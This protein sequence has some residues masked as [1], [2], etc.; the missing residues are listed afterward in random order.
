MK[1]F[2]NVFVRVWNLLSVC[3]QQIKLCRRCWHTA[4]LSRHSTDSDCWRHQ[5]KLMSRTSS[6][7][8][9]T[10]CW[11]AQTPGLTM[12]LWEVTS[13]RQN[14]DV[15]YRNLAWQSVYKK[16]RQSVKTLTCR[17]QPVM[18]FEAHDVISSDCL[19]YFCFRFT[20]LCIMYV[21]IWSSKNR[22]SKCACAQFWSALSPSCI[23]ARSS[24]CIKN[25]LVLFQT[26]FAF[27][28]EEILSTIIACRCHA[29][30]TCKI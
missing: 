21:S 10:C 19:L 28:R 23:K 22:L 9:C 14:S 12:C 30:V 18:E 1:I 11:H 5:S 3:C 15:M 27:F 2:S 6:V 24:R 26:S 13:V 16:W 4:K 29:V 17:H 20:K 7:I 8:V 25:L